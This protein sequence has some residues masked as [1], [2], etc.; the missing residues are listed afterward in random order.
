M[1]RLKQYQAFFQQH[2]AMPMKWTKPVK[3]A[4]GSF[5]GKKISGL[6][7]DNRLLIELFTLPVASRI[8]RYK[9]TVAILSDTLPRDLAC[10]SLLLHQKGVWQDAASMAQW[11]VR[12]LVAM[13]PGATVME[14]GVR[15]NK[16][17]FDLESGARLVMAHI[18]PAR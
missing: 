12:T 10:V 2:Y 18:E 6:S 3:L 14:N 5:T 17:Q 16:V 7:A 9:L 8:T 13:E 1:N 11:L 15:L 4:G